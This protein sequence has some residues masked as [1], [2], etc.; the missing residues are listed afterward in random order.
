MH[1]RPGQKVRPI[2]ARREF[3][4]QCNKNGLYP[5]PLILR[6]AG[7]HELKLAHLE[8]TEGRS[9]A[10]AK[11]LPLLPIC[12]SIDLSDCCLSSVALERTLRAIIFKERA[13]ASMYEIAIEEVQA[14]EREE[15][16][17]QRD[18]ENGGKEE[19]DQ[20]GA[21]GEKKKSEKS[22]VPEGGNND[23]ESPARGIQKLS[24]SEN[25]ISDEP[26]RRA[27]LDLCT[28]SACLTDLK[29]SNC[30]LSDVFVAKLA[31]RLEGKPSLR[32]LD[33][34]HNLIG[35]KGGIAIGKV[36]DSCRLSELNLSWNNLC[37]D[38]AVAIARAISKAKYLAILNLDMNGFGQRRTVIYE[39]GTSTS[40]APADEI[41]CAMASQES[42]IKKIGLASNDIDPVSAAVI[43]NGLAC[44][45]VH[46]VNGH[47]IEYL[48]LSTHTNPFEIQ[49]IH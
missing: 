11:S 12:T 6:Q 34:S 7:K 42:M 32:S 33:L 26:P 28:L 8:I 1:L 20:K 14:K 47:F 10:V 19:A 30:N 16:E 17:R 13:G 9:I 43:G 3:I 15:E 48:R 37:S 5:E 21:N 41:G 22:A 31:R 25:D 2:T 35:V 27:L 46:I 18:P 36:I 44:R 49:P 29:L 4:M 39:D 40:V 24:L 23:K 38:G 45:S